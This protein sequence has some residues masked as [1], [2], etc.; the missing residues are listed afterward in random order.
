MASKNS[1]SG[2]NPNPYDA[3]EVC[4]SDYKVIDSAALGSAVTA[5][6]LYNAANGNNCVTTIKST[7]VG[8]AS[9]VSAFLEVQGSARK[10]DSGSF[11][12]YAGPVSAA[13]GNKCV[14]WGGYAGSS[15]YES[16]FEHCG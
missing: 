7:S 1:C 4:G 10:S 12:Y 16:G 2:S 15:T 5:Y 14:K 13:A 3:V 9:S 8:N 11:E 6:L